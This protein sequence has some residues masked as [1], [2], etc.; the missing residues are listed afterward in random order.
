M[1]RVAFEWPSEAHLKAMREPFALKSISIE[2]G[3]NHCCTHFTGLRFELWNGHRSPAFRSKERSFET[4]TI[5][6]GDGDRI[7]KIGMATKPQ[8][9]R[10][11]PITAM[12]LFLQDGKEITQCHHKN[13]FDRKH[14]ETKY[15]E[16]K[17]DN[18]HLVG[19][20][21]IKDEKERIQALG[22]IT[23]RFQQQK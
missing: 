6:L 7:T 4:R 16:Q 21:G 3:S 23:M 1:K 19:F 17:L 13:N 14:H 15:E 8:S 12:H 22:L 2:S 9:P 18:E 11:M 20:Y 5:T 10:I